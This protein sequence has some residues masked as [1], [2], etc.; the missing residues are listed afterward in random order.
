LTAIPVW[1]FAIH[2]KGYSAKQ[3]REATDGI[4]FDPATKEDNKRAEDNKDRII[5]NE[6]QLANQSN[7]SGT[8]SKKV[9][10]PTITYAGKFDN[11]VQVGA[12][13]SGVFEDGGECTAE[14]TQ[15]NLKFAKKVTAVKNVNSVDCPEM[16]ANSSEF[17]NKGQW[18]VTVTYSSATASGTSEAKQLKVE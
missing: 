17:T 8:D 12:Y 2:G 7:S 14:F 18:T 4:N 3:S 13:V 10:K 5:E 16:A 6:N 9:V 15:G 11:Q 1:Y